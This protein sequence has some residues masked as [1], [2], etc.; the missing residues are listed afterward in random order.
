MT[1]KVLT[2]QNRLSDHKYVWAEF[3]IIIAEKP[4]QIFT[5]T[6][7]QKC[8][9]DRPLLR[10]IL[11]SPFPLTP[12]ADIIGTPDRLTTVVTGLRTFDDIYSKTASEI[13]DALRTRRLKRDITRDIDLEII[14][15]TRD[16]PDY[17]NIMDS[18]IKNH[19]SR[20][21]NVGA[22]P[23]RYVADPLPQNRQRSAHLLASMVQEKFKVK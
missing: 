19:N 5:K 2:E 12:A 20:H 22:M 13:Q 21:G 16:Q 14:E 6:T 9:A 11:S 1:S 4:E 3:N 10:A 15:A 8:W 7:I 18:I 23:V 17:Y